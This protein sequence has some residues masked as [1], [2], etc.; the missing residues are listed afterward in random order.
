MNKLVS[1][2]DYFNHRVPTDKQLHISWFF[3][4]GA[5]V[6]ALPFTTAFSSILF[7]IVVAGIWEKATERRNTTRE[8]ILDFLASCVGVVAGAIITWSAITISCG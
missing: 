8:H 1:I 2:I 6:T 3:V 7:G 5:V 4:L